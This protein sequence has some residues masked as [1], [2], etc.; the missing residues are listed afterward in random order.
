MNELETENNT[1]QHKL[2][3]TYSKMG[4]EIKRKTYEQ[5]NTVYKRSTIYSI[6]SYSANFLAEMA[7]E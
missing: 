7:V 4:P 2:K 5:I 6:Y 3:A 1:V